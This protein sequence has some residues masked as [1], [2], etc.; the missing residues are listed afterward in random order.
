MTRQPSIARRPPSILSPAHSEC[1]ASFSCKCCRQLS[2]ATA[3]DRCYLQV[4]I[5]GASCQPLVLA[6]QLLI[7]HD[8][9]KDLAL[10]ELQ[11]GHQCLDDSKLPL[12]CLGLEFPTKPLPGSKAISVRDT[13]DDP[14][15][16][17]LHQV[18]IQLLCSV[19]NILLVLHQFE[20]LLRVLLHVLQVVLLNEGQ[21][22][23]EEESCEP[24]ELS[25]HSLPMSSSL[26]SNPVNLPSRKPLALIAPPPAA[27]CLLPLLWLVRL[28]IIGSCPLG[29]SGPGDHP[30]S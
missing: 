21:V 1:Q 24:M 29:L 17:P 15:W 11:K 16:S 13:P 18:G 22:A 8:S 3:H 14:K 12:P 4:L 30:R 23:L 9:F 25:H 26:S 5:Q 19:L 2:R 27:S 28:G 20:V 6:D 10:L 7:L